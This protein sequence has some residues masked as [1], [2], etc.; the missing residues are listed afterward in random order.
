MK[1][2]KAFLLIFT[3]IFATLS[4]I[5]SHHAFAEEPEDD[6]LFEYSEEDDED[7]DDFEYS[8]EDEESDDVFFDDSSSDDEEDDDDDTPYYYGEDSGYYYEGSSSDSSDSSGS[9]DTQTGTSYSTDDSAEA[10]D[11]YSVGKVLGNTGSTEYDGVLS[12]GETTTAYSGAVPKTG[13]K[14]KRFP[15]RPE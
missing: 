3:V 5:P 6:D 8:D 9:S 1:N 11:Y 12:A 10:Y 2:F 15:N 14:Q 4:F 7:D 13:R